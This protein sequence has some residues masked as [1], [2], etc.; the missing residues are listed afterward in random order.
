[1]GHRLA[2]MTVI[3]WKASCA[4]NGR[5]GDSVRCVEWE[6]AGD[7]RRQVVISG[8]AGGLGEFW[9][10]CKSPSRR[11][12]RR[13]QPHGKGLV[14]ACRFSFQY[15]TGWCGLRQRVPKNKQS[16][17]VRTLRWQDRDKPAEQRPITNQ[18]SVAHPADA[19]VS[20]PLA[21]ETLLFLSCPKT[22]LNA[23]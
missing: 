16:K 8:G 4:H 20:S 1:M 10:I 7:K 21:A 23:L 5:R 19:L 14:P 9:L 22:A 2:A 17:C 12:R 6:V 15:R 18:W 3:R 11:R 13:G